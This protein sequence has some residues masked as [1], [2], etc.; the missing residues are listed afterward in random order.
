MRSRSSL[1]PHDAY[2]ETSM[3]KA[4]HASTSTPF[5]SLTSM[6]A[7]SEILLCVGIRWQYFLL[8]S[9]ENSQHRDQGRDP[10][11]PQ[12]ERTVPVLKVLLQ[13]KRRGRSIGVAKEQQ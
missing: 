10:S 1:T 7:D 11:P 9:Q 3:L 5:T 6:I 4:K 8:H 12:A 13:H 2:F